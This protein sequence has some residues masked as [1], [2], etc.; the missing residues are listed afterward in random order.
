M[1]EDSKEKVPFLSC[2]M[3]ETRKTFRPYAIYFAKIL[4]LLLAIAGVGVVLL[5]IRDTIKVIL[6]GVVAIAGYAVSVAIEITGI[7]VSS[8]AWGFWYVVGAIPWWGYV[9]I[10][11]SSIAWGFWYVVGAIPWWGYVLIGVVAMLVVPPVIYSTG[12]CIQ[13]R[14]DIDVK[15]LATVAI[16][17]YG[18]VGMVIYWVMGMFAFWV[19]LNPPFH[20]SLFDIASDPLLAAITLFFG[21]FAMLIWA[22]ALTVTGKPPY[23]VGAGDFKTSS[24]TSHGGDFDD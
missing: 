20:L 14:Y 13:R 5:T 6:T 11:V 10:V 21:S 4:L 24:H 1:T 17:A 18:M 7:V 15:R 22:G 8:I 16:E 23:K 3:H 19:N 2:L 9:L 12:V